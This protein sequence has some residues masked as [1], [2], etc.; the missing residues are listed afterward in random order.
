VAGG[1]PSLLNENF[2]K[3]ELGKLC[4]LCFRASTGNS[5]ETALSME[6]TVV[7]ETS[8]EPHLIF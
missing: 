4:D 2:G 5:A 7:S 3:Q 6:L 8:L 1:A